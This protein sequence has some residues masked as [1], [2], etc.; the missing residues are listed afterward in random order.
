MS[1][2]QEM[3]RAVRDINI[4]LFFSNAWITKQQM[5]GGYRRSRAEEKSIRKHQISVHDVHTLTEDLEVSEAPSGYSLHDS[6]SREPDTYLRSRRS[7]LSRSSA[8]LVL[9]ET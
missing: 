8:A 9:L 3:S 1:G 2:F 5:N 6:I 4:W 7:I